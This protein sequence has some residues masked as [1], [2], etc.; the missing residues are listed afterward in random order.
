MAHIYSTHFTFKE[1]PDIHVSSSE[2]EHI[3]LLNI[4]VRF[5]PLGHKEDFGFPK[6]PFSEQFLKEPFFL[7]VMNIWITWW[8]LPL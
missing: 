2:K 4:K 1:Q 5:E 8:T 3:T 6:E 7:N